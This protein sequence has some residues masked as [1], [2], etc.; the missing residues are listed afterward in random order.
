MK[1]LNAVILSEAL[2]RTVQ[3]EAKNP[4]SCSFNELR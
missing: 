1:R 4:G 2:D 3:G